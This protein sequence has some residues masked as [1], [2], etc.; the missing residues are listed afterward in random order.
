MSN[1][2]SCTDTWRRTPGVSFMQCGTKNGPIWDILFQLGTERIYSPKEIVAMQ[3]EPA[4]GVH[5]LKMGQLKTSIIFSGGKEKLFFVHRPPDLFGNTA[6]IDRGPY[7][8]T[9]IALRKSV[10]SFI[11]FNEMTQVMQENRKVSDFIAFSLACR[12][13]SLVKQAESLL[14]T[15]EQKL[16]LLLLEHADSP[17][18]MTH[19]EIA[20]FLGASRPQITVLL[21]E[22]KG[23]GIIAA[24]TRHIYLEKP[25]ELKRI[26]EGL[27]K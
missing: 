17:L 3:G 25:Q 10:V 21:N 2:Y 13:R 23:K 20:M 16:A 1:G 9:I 7:I 19:E 15:V 4:Q 8:C 11:P 22:W 14:F 26:V 27:E 18:N 12:I 6:L 5:I 24:K